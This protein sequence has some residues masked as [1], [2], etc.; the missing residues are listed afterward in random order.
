MIYVV[1]L[2]SL[3]K[4]TRAY[5]KYNFMPFF[6]LQH[7]TNSVTFLIRTCAYATEK[8]EIMLEYDF[9]FVMK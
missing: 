8:N 9:Q 3:R 6:L 2:E 4:H 1:E 7:F 5:A